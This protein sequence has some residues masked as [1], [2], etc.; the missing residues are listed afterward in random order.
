MGRK[1]RKSDDRPFWVIDAE[2]DPFKHGRIP[3]PFIW[4]LYDGVSF[5]TFDTTAEMVAYIREHDVIVYAHNGGKFDFHFLLNEIN[6]CEPVTVING[7]LVVSH[8]G[9]CELRDSWNILPIPL[10]RYQKD[11]IDYAIMER[12]KREKP[13]NRRKIIEYLRGD[14][15]YLHELIYTFEEAYGRHLT[16]AGASMHVWQQMHGEK[17]PQSSRDFYQDFSKYYYGGRVECFASGVIPGPLKVIDIKSAYPWAMLSPHPYSLEYAITHHPKTVAPQSMVTVECASYG[18]LPFRTEKGAMIF[19]NDDERRTFY[20]T[21]H[22]YMAGLE[23]GSLIDPVVTKCVDFTRLVDFTPYIERFFEQRRQADLRD[24]VAMNIFAKLFMNGLYGKFAANPDNYGEFMCVPF[25]A[26]EDYGGENYTF[27][28]MIGPHGL[29]KRPLNWHE[30]RFYNVA[31]AASITGQV[32]AHLWRTIHASQG[33]VYCD[34]D[35]IICRDHNAPIG[36]NL[37]MWTDEGTAT[38]CY[39]A[40]KK[41]YSLK[42]SFGKGKEYKTATKGVRLTHEQIKKVAAGEAVTFASDAPTFRLRG[43]TIFQKRN[44]KMTAKPVGTSPD[45]P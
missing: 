19:P 27:E 34:T 18:A 44:V 17:A 29:L 6:L 10:A 3:E 23:T 36:S 38:E 37:G 4:G 25:G 13:E 16:Q 41:L 14:C 30:Q 11:E 1:R 2:T 32:R 31:C 43:E 39:I 45:A 28:G 33:V 8:I 5:E 24:D 26:I 35:S 21:G 42:G 7:R 15:I 9:K 20:V 40:G 22:E 12:G